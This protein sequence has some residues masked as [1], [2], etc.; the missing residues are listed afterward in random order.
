[1]YGLSLDFIF[2]W[3][4]SEDQD[5]TVD[6]RGWKKD[7]PRMY[8]KT[9]EQSIL[10][11]HQQLDQDPK[12]FFS[13]ASV[14]QQQYRTFY[15]NTRVPSLRFIGRTL[16]KHGLSKAPKVRRKGVSR[17]LHY[18]E[19]LINNLGES[20]LEVDFI[21]K[22]F[23][24]GKTEPVHFIAFSLKKPR[25]LKYFQRIESETSAQ[26]IHHCRLLFKRYEKPA[27]V[28]L[29]NGFAFAGSGPEPRTLNSVVLF[30]LESKIIPV[31]TAPRKPWNQ[32]SVEGANSVFSRKFWNRFRFG[33]LSQVDD[34]LD[35]FNDAYE[36]YLEYKKPRQTTR[37][38][39]RY[40]PQ[41]YFIRKVYEHPESQRGY[42]D[43]VKEQIFLPKTY[44]GLFVL[45]EWNLSEEKLTVYFEKDKIPKI[46]KKQKF[47]LNPMTKQRV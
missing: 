17:Y 34:H 24:Q 38:K 40:I 5:L 44:I 11:I 6:G 39:G 22:K 14:I 3:T 8:T 26:V 1:M 31:F 2:S 16:V 13:G 21:G 32:A 19:A 41:V 12:I 23:I 9:E 36:N 29:D 27:V 33:S 45:A 18:P 25:K 47:V 37:S 15:P 7:R 46:V 30:L 42:I 20:L 43:V 35:A 28:K 4:K 10:R